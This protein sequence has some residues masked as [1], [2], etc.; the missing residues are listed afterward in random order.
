[1]IV[2]ISLFFQ[3]R[4]HYAWLF[5]R[6]FIARLHMQWWLQERSQPRGVWDEHCLCPML[7]WKQ[8]QRGWRRNAEKQHSNG[9]IESQSGQS[10]AIKWGAPVEKKCKFNNYLFDDFPCFFKTDG[11]V[12]LNTMAID[13]GHLGDSNLSFCLR[14]TDAVSRVGNNIV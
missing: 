13:R 1:M 2:F 3:R 14:N 8:V 4:S 12:I 11:F 7:H 5:K 10:G 9:A 6:R